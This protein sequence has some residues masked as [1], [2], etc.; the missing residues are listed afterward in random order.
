MK[1]AVVGTG[2]TGRR[3]ISNLL[4]LGE[5]NV[6]AVSEFSQ[7]DCLEL[8]GVSVPIS[9]TYGE[10]LDTVDAV[11]I[12]NPTSM[13]I[14]YL[15]RAVEHG[16]HVYVEKPVATIVDGIEELAELADR[17]GV[18]VA[19]GNQFRFNERIVDLRKR[20]RA[21][22]IGKII[23]VH[24]HHGE[25]VADYHPD[26]DYRQSYTSR[27][28]LGGGV[29]LT[30]IHHIDYLNWM[31]GPFQSVS[32]SGGES[33]AL[34]LDVED[35]VTYLL[36][37]KAGTAVSGHMNFL[38]RP[39]I[40]TLDI[41]GVG[42]SFHWHYEENSVKFLPARNNAFFVTESVPLMRNE[43]FLPCMKNFLSSISSNNKPK[44][45]LVDG[46]QAL[47]IVNAIKQAMFSKE[48]VD[49]SQ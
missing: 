42:G 35:H 22:E 37:S 14:E 44:S 29:L 33:G 17:K 21:G 11:I 32:A 30:Q 10:V 12:A 31:F 36:Q 38:Q 41:H 34:E 48:T 1:I 25:H 8:E 28:E 24:S 6:M 18:V 19:V 5:R 15:W 16:I 49:I 13:H 4:A 43:M 2:S 3:H 40:T 47:H 27:H 46:L 26:E 20:I 9:H 45:G 39:K 7:K 23:A